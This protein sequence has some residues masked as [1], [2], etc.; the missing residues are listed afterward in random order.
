MYRIEI[1]FYRISSINPL[2][3]MMISLFVLGHNSMCSKEIRD[4]ELE[5]QLVR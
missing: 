4:L 2:A 1:R 3:A 5:I